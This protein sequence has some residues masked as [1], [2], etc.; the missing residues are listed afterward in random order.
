M[1]LGNLV[2][3]YICDDE[4]NIE[5]VNKFFGKFKDREDI[6]DKSQSDFLGEKLSSA[7]KLD[8]FIQELREIMKPA[9]DEAFSDRFKTYLKKEYGENGEKI[10]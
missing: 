4:T 3:L 6:K 2:D 9:L 1:D 8:K 7:K 5:D 10:K